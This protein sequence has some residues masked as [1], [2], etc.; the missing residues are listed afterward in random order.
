MEVSHISAE[1]MEQYAF[2]RLAEAECAELEGHLL[3]C[4]ACR[5]GL[6]GMDDY[7]AV[8]KTALTAMSLEKGDADSAIAQT[9][10]VGD[11][12]DADRAG[13]GRSVR[14]VDLEHAS[15]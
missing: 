14:G 8:M 3:S 9:G 4:S 10:A 2:A 5:E 1:R 13:I 6:A 12:F 7:I 15:F 11:A